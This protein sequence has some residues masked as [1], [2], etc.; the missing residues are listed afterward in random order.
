MYQYLDAAKLWYK[1]QFFL[2]CGKYF[3]YFFRYQSGI[4]MPVPVEFGLHDSQL[5][6]YD[7]Y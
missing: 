1:I 4:E 7:S 3:R 6:C 2:D 5:E